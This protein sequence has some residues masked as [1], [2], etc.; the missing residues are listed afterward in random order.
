MQRMTRSQFYDHLSI[1]ETDYS[2]R[3]LSGAYT[4]QKRSE[5][6]RDSEDS[7]VYQVNS[8]VFN[9]KLPAQVVDLSDMPHNPLCTCKA[10]HNVNHCR[11]SM[12]VIAHNDG[13][14]L[15]F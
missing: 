15:T 1:R 12:L 14:T 8:S 4:L 5:V 7:D 9:H 2:R 3:E 11:H 6:V 13:I 10:L